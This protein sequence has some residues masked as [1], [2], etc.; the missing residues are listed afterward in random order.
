MMYP[1]AETVINPEE[2]AFNNNPNIKLNAILTIIKIANLLFPY[3][4]TNLDNNFTKPKVI[5]LINNVNKSLSGLE[6]YNTK[7]LGTIIPPGEIS[8]N[9]KNIKLII[10]PI[11]MINSGIIIPPHVF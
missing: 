1:T 8:V 5:K 6:I 2:I 10:T 3:I 11:I 4:N 9:S 7:T